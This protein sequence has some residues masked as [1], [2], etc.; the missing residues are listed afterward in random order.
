MTKYPAIQYSLIGADDAGESR[1]PT[2]VVSALGITYERYE[3][4]LIADQ[5]MFYRCANV[6][7]KL[8]EFLSLID[9]A[10]EG[11]TE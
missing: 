8:P 9:R 11:A 3:S 4:Q 5:Y 10:I 6:P 1:H 2:L 7:E